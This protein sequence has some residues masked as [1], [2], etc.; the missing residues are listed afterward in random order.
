MPAIVV[1][2]KIRPYGSF[3]GSAAATTRAMP[4]ETRN[5]HPAG[6]RLTLNAEEIR[7]TRRLAKMTAM[8]IAL[9]TPAKCESMKI[10]MPPIVAKR[11]STGAMRSRATSGKAWTP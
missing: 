3:I 10:S 5:R 9:A 7:D 8:R 1:G 11:P 2:V 6:L 4:A